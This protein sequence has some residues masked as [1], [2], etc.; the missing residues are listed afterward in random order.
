MQHSHLRQDVLVFET[1]VL[2]E[3]LRLAGP[4]SLVLYASS[5]C[6]DTDFTGKMVDVDEGGTGRIVT[7]GI[8]RARFRNGPERQD[9]LE[10]GKMEE[11]RVSLGA[12]AHVFG[13]GHRMRLEVSSS[14]FPKF[15]RN[16]N[17]MKLPWLEDRLAAALQE[18]Y[19]GTRT[20]SRLEVYCLR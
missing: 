6:P 13:R 2:E 20:P 15:D 18:V 17:T 12:C 4:V 10:P 5:S 3:P 1:A 8:I 9:F 14:N 7:D 19:F 16:M 11:F